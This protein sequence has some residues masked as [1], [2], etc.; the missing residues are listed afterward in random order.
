[1]INCEGGWEKQTVREH[2]V[3]SMQAGLIMCLKEKKKGVRDDANCAQSLLKCT[4]ADTQTGKSEAS[5]LVGS[6]VAARTDQPLCPG[7]SPFPAC[8]LI[9]PSARFW[10]DCTVLKLTSNTHTHTHARKPPMLPSPHPLPA[11]LACSRLVGIPTACCT[12]IWLMEFDFQRGS[13]KPVWLFGTVRM[14]GRREKK[15]VWSWEARNAWRGGGTVLPI[16]SWKPRFP[17]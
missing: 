14:R 5:R 6:E 9:P 12:V 10:G 3:L 13:L 17:F 1:M 2:L 16:R 4:I 8:F 15:K 7:P 11:S